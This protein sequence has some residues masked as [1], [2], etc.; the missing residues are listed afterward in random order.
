VEDKP[1]N[2][3]RIW[4]TLSPVDAMEE[5]QSAAAPAARP[6]TTIVRNVLFLPVSLSPSVPASLLDISGRKVLDLCAGAND[7]SR[8]SPGVYFVTEHCPAGTFEASGT[9]NAVHVRKVIVA[10]QGYSQ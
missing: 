5:G 3:S 1:Y 9:R 8:L 6:A 4:A 7:V 10:G 2:S